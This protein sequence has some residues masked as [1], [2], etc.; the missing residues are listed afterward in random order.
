M[1]G[2]TRSTRSGWPRFSGPGPS[3]PSAQKGICRKEGEYWTVGVGGKVFQLKD[4]K[5]LA[6]LAHLPRYPAAEFHVLDLAAGIADRS[7]EDGLLRSD[8][9]LEKAGLHIGSLGDAGAADRVVGNGRKP[10][11]TARVAPN[12]LPSG[13]RS[14]RTRLGCVEIEPGHSN[15]RHAFAVVV[16]RPLHAP[17]SRRTPSG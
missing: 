14:G 3:M 1:A 12:D 13:A 6:Y 9:D 15:P 10:S 2:R 8:D 5:G 17:R 16:S 11:G 7:G 4:S